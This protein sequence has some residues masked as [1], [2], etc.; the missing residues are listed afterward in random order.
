MQAGGG[1]SDSASRFA[2]STAHTR[3]QRPGSVEWRR[4]VCCCARKQGAS[5]AGRRATIRELSSPVV[6]KSWEFRGASSRSGCARVNRLSCIIGG[7]SRRQIASG[8]LPRR[9]IFGASAQVQHARLDGTHLREAAQRGSHKYHAGPRPL[10]APTPS[11]LEKACLSAPSSHGRR[12]R[13]LA[14]LGV[15][16]RPGA[17]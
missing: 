12:P 10:G 5:A 1:A 6:A 13:C 2:Q 7:G 4:V 9:A 8:G 11:G 15:E 16:Y 14:C 3:R 17:Y